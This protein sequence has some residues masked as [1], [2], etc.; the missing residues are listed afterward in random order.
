MTRVKIKF[1]QPNEGIHRITLL[2][3]LSSHNIYATRIIT[4]KDGY[5][6][7]TRTDEDTEHLLSKDVSTQLKSKGFTPVTPPE[8]KAKRTTIITRLDNHIYN[9]TPEDIK[10]EIINQNSWLS[11]DDI[12]EI[13]KFP[14]SNTI[15]IIFLQTSAAKK[16][17][18][19]G[20]LLFSMSIPPNQ[21]QEETYIHIITCMRCYALEDHHTSQC[22]K[23]KEYKICSECGE[24]GHTWFTCL[25]E[26]KRCINCGNNHRTLAM[27][28]PERK[29]L[30]TE[31]R[32]ANTITSTSHT[33]TSYSSAAKSAPIT[34]TL[35]NINLHKDTPC[36]ILTCLLHAHVCNIGEPGSF[37]KV[38]QEML[39]DN[40]LPSVKVSNTPNSK[41]IME[42]ANIG[43]IE[44]REEAEEVGD[45]ITGTSQARTHTTENTEELST[46]Q[47]TQR[48]HNMEHETHTIKGTAIGLAII[49]SKATGWPEEHLSLK[50]LTQGLESKKYKWAYT[51]NSYDE[52]TVY[53]YIT[54]DKIDLHGCWKVTEEDNFRKFRSG[55]HIDKTPPPPK[56]RRQRQ[57]NN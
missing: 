32:Q 18:T 52:D 44:E 5:I 50:K 35:P 15:K 21:I 10:N 20:L 1:K 47:N 56:H 34:S 53:Q 43:G 55:L 26:E 57:T 54:T 37:E 19:N 25:N 8:L 6:V 39:K 7:L 45:E 17:Q 4:T 16:A 27:R 46:H 41:K 31:K 51:D 13:Y 30:I 42:M 36:K 49:T 9:N 40:N 29:K 23:P 22:Q 38:L 2:Q 12:E 33:A 11:E 28:C 24:L 14:N 3:T 48:T